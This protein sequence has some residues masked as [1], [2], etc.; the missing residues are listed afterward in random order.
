[1]ILL[2]LTGLA[3]F[4]GVAPLFGAFVAGIIARP[5][6]PEGERAHDAIRQFAFASFVPAYFAI[7]SLRLDLTAGFDL[8]FFATLLL[9]ACFVKAASVYA[10][11]RLAGERPTGARNLAAALN[12]RGGP[13]IVLASVAFDAVPRDIDRRRLVVGVRR[14]SRG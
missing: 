13:G 14:S 5:T 2:L 7:V 3:L 8:R 1:L 12:C 11:A 9:W 10:G 6:D 4:M